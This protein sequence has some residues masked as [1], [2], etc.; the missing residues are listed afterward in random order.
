[1]AIPPRPL[2]PVRFSAEI[3]RVRAS[4]NSGRLA[5]APGATRTGEVLVEGERGLEQLVRPTAR[6]REIKPRLIKRC[7]TEFSEVPAGVQP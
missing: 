2:A 6:A 3:E 5:K 4:F 1:M 7:M